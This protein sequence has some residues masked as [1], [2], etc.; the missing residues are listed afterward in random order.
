MFKNPYKFDF[1][2]YSTR[3]GP[4]VRKNRKFAYAAWFA[5]SYCVLVNCIAA[6]SAKKLWQAFKS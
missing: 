5:R 6:R 3:L 2:S 1:L 4:C